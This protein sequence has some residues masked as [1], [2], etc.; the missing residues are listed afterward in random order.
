MEGG[1]IRCQ[2]RSGDG[3]KVRDLDYETD[4]LAAIDW[5]GY[6]P[7]GVVQVIPENAQEAVSQLQVISL[8]GD[9]HGIEVGKPVAFSGEAMRFDPAYAARAIPIWCRTPSLRVK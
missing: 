6:D 1:G 9:G 7:A 5:R 8:A 2:A 4:L 3:G